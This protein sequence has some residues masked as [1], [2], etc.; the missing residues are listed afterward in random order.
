M[1]Y[2]EKNKNCRLSS[3]TVLNQINAIQSPISGETET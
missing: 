2:I 3:N 1:L